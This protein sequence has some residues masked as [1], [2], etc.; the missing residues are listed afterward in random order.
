VEKTNALIFT[1]IKKIVENKLKGKWTEGLSRVVWNHNTSICRATKFIP[2]KLLYREEPIT[3]EEIKLGSARTNTEAVY[4]PT[5]AES[6]DLLKPEQMK[7]D[8][9][10]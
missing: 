9:K 3:P 7:A 4:S 10:H 2:F 1:A 5:E 8:E 6:K